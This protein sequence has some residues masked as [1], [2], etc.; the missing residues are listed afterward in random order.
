[1]PFSLEKLSKEVADDPR[2]SL[3][4]YIKYVSAVLSLLANLCCGRNKKSLTQIKNTL[5][6]SEN[7]VYNALRSYDLDI[8]IKTSYF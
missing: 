2:Q 1:M 6:I 8:N 4:P 3:K 5:G 7:H